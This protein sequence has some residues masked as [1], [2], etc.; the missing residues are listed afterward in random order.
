MCL[1]IDRHALMRADSS[2]GGVL[3]VCV[4]VRS[5]M[6]YV[7]RCVCMHVGMCAASENSIVKTTT[8]SVITTTAVGKARRSRRL[9]T[10]PIVL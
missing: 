8:T 2:V 6:S 3:C 10:F 4:S 1:D 7:S 5:C 9:S